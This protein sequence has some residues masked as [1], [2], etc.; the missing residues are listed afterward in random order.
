MSPVSL[1]LNVILFYGG[2][3]EKKFLHCRHNTKDPKAKGGGRSP[4][5]RK[6]GYRRQQSSRYFGWWEQSHVLCN[7]Y[8]GLC[9]EELQ[10]PQEA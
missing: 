8:R 6:E 2:D 3:G 10:C 4:S 9:Q 1:E 5:P 7:T